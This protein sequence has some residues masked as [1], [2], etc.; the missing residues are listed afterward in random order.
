[1]SVGLSCIYNNNNN[2][3]HYSCHYSY[4]RN[5]NPKVSQIV[6]EVSYRLEGPSLYRPRSIAQQEFQPPEAP[7]PEVGILQFPL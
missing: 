2:K 4:N 6:N 7:K 5:V 3:L 1:M